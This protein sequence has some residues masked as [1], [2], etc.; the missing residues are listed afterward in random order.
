MKLTKVIEFEIDG[1]VSMA[2]IA[3]IGSRIELPEMNPMY[4][5][6]IIG[7]NEHNVTVVS[8]SKDRAMWT[9][10]ISVKVG[11]EEIG[12]NALIALYERRF[13]YNDRKQK[14]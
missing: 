5:H 9:I 14:Q 6:C 11:K 7:K 1:A 13:F 10:C 4:K 3:I 8:V 12:A 2:E